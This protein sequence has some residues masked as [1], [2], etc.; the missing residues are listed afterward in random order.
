MPPINRR[1]LLVVT[2]GAAALAVAPPLRAAVGFD[3]DWFLLLSARLTGV[4]LADLDASA[5]RSILAGI[6][7]LG[8]GGELDS[9]AAEPDAT[10]PLANDIVAAW[11]SGT[12]DTG[13]DLAS[14]GLT[15]ALLWKALDYTEP[16]GLCGGKT[17]H[18]AA[19]A[20]R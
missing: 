8:R 2:A 7:A 18:W 5:A 3:V 17:G 1:D 16:P 9:L 13:A 4:S 12:Y 20:A 19:P 6:L 14:F 15:H 10:A 11:Y